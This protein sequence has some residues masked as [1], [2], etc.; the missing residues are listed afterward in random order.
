M[1]GVFISLAALGAAAVLAGCDLGQDA[2]LFD[3]HRFRTKLSKQD[4]RHV[5]VV[6]AS[7]VSASRVGAAE[8]ARYAATRYCV[9]NFGSSEIVWT[10][11]PDQDLDA[12]PVSDDRL[13]LQGACPQ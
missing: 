13:T 1:R 2:T 4:A 9:S 3:G 12:L 10:V 5:F 6:T 11:G 7:P 8:A